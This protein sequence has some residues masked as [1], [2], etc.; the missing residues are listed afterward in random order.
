MGMACFS[1]YCGNTNV[2]VGHQNADE[3]VSEHVGM[4][5]PDTG[6]VSDSFDDASITVRIERQ[7]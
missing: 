1:S 5:M 2:R 3:S 6:F 4:E 7:P